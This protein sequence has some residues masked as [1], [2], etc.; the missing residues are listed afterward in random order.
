[1]D[2]GPVYRVMFEKTQEMGKETGG[3]G[4]ILSHTGGID[5]PEFKRYPTKWTDDTRA[6]WTV[7]DPTKDFYSWMP[8]VALKENIAMY[9]DPSKKTSKIPFLTNDM[10]GFDL[11]KAGETDEE[12]Y[13]LWM[14]FSLLG[15]ITEVFSQAGN[16]TS[17]LPWKYSK[18]ADS[19]FLKYARLR[20]KL[21]PYIYSYAHH[22]R[23]KGEH[24]IG[25]FPEHIYQYMFGDEMLVAP[26]Y[27]QGDSS[28]SVHLPKG[29]WINY[30][31]H[32]RVEGNQSI[33]AAAPI[34][35]I[36]VFVKEGA[37][38][39]MRNYA[40]SI[41]EGNND[42]LDVHLYPG[43]D[44][45]FT[46]IEDDG[47]SNDYQEGIYAKTTMK[48]TEGKNSSKLNIAPTKGSYDQMKEIRTWVF[49]SIP[50]RM[51][52]ELK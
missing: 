5:D 48:L 3:R 24:M 46:L 25:K 1:M 17:N 30:W 49:T 35:R 32:E 36:P 22:S 4:F 13:I 51:L 41:E 39:P 47:T 27:K 7:E 9:T 20:M 19:L 34:D 26:V 52:A 10:G 42:V 15:P 33:K 28:R 2:K 21:F 38:I 14:Q 8:Q 45:Q 16:P 44:G 40:P 43:R 37:I 50:L 29:K 6:D 12:L 11:G 23:L 18:R 31:T